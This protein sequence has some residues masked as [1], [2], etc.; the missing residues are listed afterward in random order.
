MANITAYLAS[1][2]GFSEAGQL[3]MNQ[4][5]LP[6]LKKLGLTILNPWDALDSTSA[7]FEKISKI[8]N[9][10]K[11]VSNLKSF[12]L[13]IAKSNEDM[14]NKSNIVIA[15]L[16]GT[17]VDSGVSAEI[18]FAYAKGKKIIG[19]RG[20]FRITGDNVGATVN[21]QVEYFITNSKGS[22]VTNLDN[23]ISIIKNS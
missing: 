3:F 11:L 12:N 19:Y 6:E 5:L 7:E 22:I 15:V 20:D 14:I 10:Q 16:D 18:G 2:L 23:L 1:P 21:L 17:D 4:K 8:E 13:K 9:N